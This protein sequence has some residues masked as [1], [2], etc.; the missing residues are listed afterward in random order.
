M[1]RSG[2]S[3]SGPEE[4]LLTLDSDNQGLFEQTISRIRGV[5]AGMDQNP[6]HAVGFENPF[7]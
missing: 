5:R 4:L 7:L 3:Y 6:A 2:F 1:P